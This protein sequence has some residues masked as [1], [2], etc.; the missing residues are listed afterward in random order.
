MATVDTYAATAEVQAVIYTASGLP[1]GS[2]T[3]V[4]EVTGLRNAAANDSIIVVDAFDVT[5]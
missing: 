1:S 3:L 4:I 2:H 5:S